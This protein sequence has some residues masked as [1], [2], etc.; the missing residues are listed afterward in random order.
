MNAYFRMDKM[1]WTCIRSAGQL[2]MLKMCIEWCVSVLKIRGRTT[3]SEEN[4]LS[5]IWYMGEYIQQG[6]WCLCMLWVRTL[7]QWPVGSRRGNT[8]FW[9]EMVHPDLATR[10]SFVEWHFGREF[11]SQ[12]ELQDV[13]CIM[14][15]CVCTNL[16][17]VARIRGF[18]CA[19]FSHLP[20]TQDTTMIVFSGCHSSCSEGERLLISCCAWWFV[21][22]VLGSEGVMHAQVIGGC[23]A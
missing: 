18:C 20:I 22:R 19:A 15:C 14:A 16:W 2:L 1:P 3:P 8:R 5:G 4:T 13:I 21:L 12:R 10:T 6:T 9:W 7:L 17:V 23:Q 11:R